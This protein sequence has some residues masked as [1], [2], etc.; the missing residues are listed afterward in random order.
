MKEGIE[1]IIYIWIGLF[2]ELNTCSWGID[3]L[4]EKIFSG[5][6]NIKG[7]LEFVV[8]CLYRFE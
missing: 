4:M 3:N 8:G 1:F 7:R 5:V 6:Y 2:I